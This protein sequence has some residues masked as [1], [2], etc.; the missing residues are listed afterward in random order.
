MDESDDD[1]DDKVSVQNPSECFRAS[2]FPAW[3]GQDPFFVSL[4]L[5]LGPGVIMIR[6]ISFARTN[7]IYIHR[8]S[9]WIDFNWLTHL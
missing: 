9:A 1:L 8:E 3:G 2:N 5:V 4:C 6:T 7:R